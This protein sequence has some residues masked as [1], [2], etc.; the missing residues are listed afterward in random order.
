MSTVT[1]SA[2]VPIEMTKR[3]NSVGYPVSDVIQVSVNIFLDLSPDRQSTLILEHIR[4]KNMY[5]VMHKYGNMT[6]S[7]CDM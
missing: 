3:I 1:I 4:R 5:K 2:K 7:L 6:D